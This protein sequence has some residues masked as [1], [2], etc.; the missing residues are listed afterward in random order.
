MDIKTLEKEDRAVDLRKKYTL[1]GMTG[2]TA[3]LYNRIENITVKVD[4]DWLDLY[5]DE[6]WNIMLSD[7]G[8]AIPIAAKFEDYEWGFM[9]GWTAIT[10]YADEKGKTVGYMFWHDYR[11]EYLAL[12]QIENMLERDEGITFTNLTV[13]D[14]KDKKKGIR[15]NLR[16]FM[17]ATIP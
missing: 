11:L 9:T 10:R 16:S 3:Y 4:K 15:N 1:V 13:I 5:V 6:T 17:P 14:K 7:D 8:E 2:N 12:G